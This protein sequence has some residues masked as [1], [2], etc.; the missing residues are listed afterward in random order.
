MIKQQKGQVM[1]PEKNKDIITQSYKKAI[2][3][4]KNKI[5]R[6]RQNAVVSVNKELIFLYW[7]I[8]N[9]ILQKQEN[10]G[11]GAKVID[12]MSTDLSRE[13]ADMKG[14]SVRNLKYMLKF[15]EENKY[16]A[17]VQQ[18]VAQLPWGSNIVLLN[19]LNSQA[20]RLWYAKKAIENGWSRNVLAHQIESGL[21][22]RQVSGSKTHNFRKTLQGTQSDLA[23]ETIKD[24]YIFDFLN[25]SEQV[26]EKE[27][28]TGLINHL[29]SFL[30]ELGKGFAYVGRQYHLEAGGEDFLYRPAFLSS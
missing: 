13:F 17:I 26:S 16:R 3:D 9:I 14:F 1:K 15:A 27:L 4:I 28:E 5:L 11:W 6:A 24:P 18:V 23:H 29:A 10:E 22:K 30:L 12:R 20:D 7:E 25:M 8:G 21:Y 2:K 19:K